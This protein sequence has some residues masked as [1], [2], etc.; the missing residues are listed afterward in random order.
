MSSHSLPEAEPTKRSL[1]RAKCAS[2]N[3]PASFRYTWPGQRSDVLCGRH[4]TE[5]AQHSDPTKLAVE[6]LADERLIPVAVPGGEIAWRV[7]PA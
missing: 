3:E 7:V 1:P 5:L 2:C 6:P 4:L